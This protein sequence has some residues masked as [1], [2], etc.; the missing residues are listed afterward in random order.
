[1]KP[2]GE[3]QG[4]EPGDPWKEC[5]EVAVQ[6]ALRAGQVSRSDALRPRGRPGPRA[7]LPSRSVAPWREP[8]PS[9]AQCS[10]PNF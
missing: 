1:M 5:V 10:G 8:S 9:S 3:Q 6:L 4:P 2:S 7:S